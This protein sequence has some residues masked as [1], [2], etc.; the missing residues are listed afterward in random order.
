MA[1]SGDVPGVYDVVID[2]QGYLFYEQMD[3]AATTFGHIPQR[4]LY[5]Y[6]P[7]FIERTNI[8][9]DYGDNQQAFW[10]TVS[11]RDW[12]LGEEQ[13]YYRG[14]DAVSARR[15]YAGTN[16]DISIPGQAK[17]AWTNLSA[18]LPQTSAVST[19]YVAAGHFGRET[20]GGEV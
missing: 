13:K 9:G 15:Y 5:G 1:T 6:T 20:G 8:T 12:S 17:L 10:L 16:L 18:T 11:D 14:N 3:V 4:A 2:G 19:I 7:T